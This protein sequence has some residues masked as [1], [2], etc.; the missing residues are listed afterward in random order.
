MGEATARL[1]TLPRV[2]EVLLAD[3][4]VSR[5]KG[6]RPPTSRLMVASHHLDVT[7]AEGWD[8]AVEACNNG[9]GRIDILVNSAGI[10]RGG[11]LEDETVEDHELLLRTNLTMVYPTGSVPSY[12]P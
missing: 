10:G 5:G 12:Q 7:S 9:F 3:V 6:N 4:N 1:S 11:R 2:V 8:A